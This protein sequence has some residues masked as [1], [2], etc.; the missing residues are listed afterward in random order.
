ML[1]VTYLG[2]EVALPILSSHN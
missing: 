1:L 2:L